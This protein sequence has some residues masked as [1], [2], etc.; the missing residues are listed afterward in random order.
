MHRRNLDGTHDAICLQCYGL[1]AI[2]W[3]PS[4][5]LQAETQHI[6]GKTGCDVLGLSS[7]IGCSA[8]ALE[9]EMKANRISAPMKL[10]RDEPLAVPVRNAALCANSLLT[11]FQFFLARIHQAMR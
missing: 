11:T 10:R 3:A 4:E 2:K 7:L 9:L 1:V 5:L 6:C 8:F